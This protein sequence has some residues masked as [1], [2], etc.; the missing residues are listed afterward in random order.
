M[1]EIT[2]TK[3]FYQN[4]SLYKPDRLCKVCRQKIQSKR[5]KVKFYLMG[6]TKN[7]YWKVKFSNLKTIHTYSPHFFKEIKSP[8]LTP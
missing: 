4:F 6:I 5:P 2:P 8:P 3:A 7:G 1:K